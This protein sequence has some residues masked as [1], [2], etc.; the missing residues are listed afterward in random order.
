MGVAISCVVGDL[1]YG[2]ILRAGGDPPPGI[3]CFGAGVVTPPET[4]I[5]AG[6]VTPPDDEEGTFAL[7]QAVEAAGWESMQVSSFP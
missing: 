7:P 4:G 5:G 1:E 2:P 6:V 3:I